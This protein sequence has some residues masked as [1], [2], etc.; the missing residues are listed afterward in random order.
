MTGNPN[1]EWDKEN[2]RTVSCRLRTEEYERFRNLCRSKGT[3]VHSALSRYIHTELS[4]IPV[5]RPK[6]QGQD[7]ID[8]N[9]ALQQKLVIVEDQLATARRQRDDWESIEKRREEIIDLYLR[10]ADR[11]L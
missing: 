8:Q 11:K 1:R 9:I 4:G 3:T 5:D 2:M 7:L 10:S 6:E